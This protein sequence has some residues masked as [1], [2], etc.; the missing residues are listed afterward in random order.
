MSYFDPYYLYS[1]PQRKTHKGQVIQKR[2]T[3]VPYGINDEDMKKAIHVLKNYG[4]YIS[5]NPF[6]SYPQRSIITFDKQSSMTNTSTSHLRT[7]GDLL[8][9]TT[10]LRNNLLQIFS[11][12]FSSNTVS[13]LRIIVSIPFVSVIHNVMSSSN[14]ITYRNRLKDQSS[15]IQIGSNQGPVYS[16]IQSQNTDGSTLMFEGCYANLQITAP[17]ARSTMTGA[18][19]P[20]IG[21]SIFNYVED[22]DATQANSYWSYLK[23]G[24]VYDF[25]TTPAV[26]ISTSAG[27]LTWTYANVNISILVSY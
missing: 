12:E 10:N 3:D 22:M 14:V 6:P 17:Y 5:K 19:D 27:N 18:Q 20:H 24:S 25:P 16:V 7:I 23:T 15:T 8:T 11:E 2:P 1:H 21:S 9:I 4:Y 26:E 13:A